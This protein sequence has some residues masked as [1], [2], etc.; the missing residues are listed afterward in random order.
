MKLK[1]ARN[2]L[3]IYLE[4]SRLF[5]CQLPLSGNVF[6]YKLSDSE[7]ENLMDE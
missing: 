5:F 7:I 3:F 6:D 4:P 2:N 1:F